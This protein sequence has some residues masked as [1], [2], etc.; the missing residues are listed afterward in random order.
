LK[1]ST[2]NSFRFQQNSNISLRQLNRRPLGCVLKSNYKGKYKMFTKIRLLNLL[3]LV[4]LFFYQLIAQSFQD[5]VDHYS[6]P[7][8]FSKPAVKVIFIKF[9][10]Q[11]IEGTKSIC[12]YLEL[13]NKDSFE[14]YR[15]S[16]HLC[17]SLLSLLQKESDRN[18]DIENLKYCKRQVAIMQTLIESPQKTSEEKHHAL[19]ICTGAKYGLQSSLDNLLDIIAAFGN[20]WK[21]KKTSFSMI[22][23]CRKSVGEQVDK[24]LLG[25]KFY[26]FQ[27]KLNNLLDKDV[28]FDPSTEKFTVVTNIGR[29]YQNIIPNRDDQLLIEESLNGE[30]KQALFDKTITIYQGSDTPIYLLFPS[31]I[32]SP[33]SWDHIVFESSSKRKSESLGKTSLTRLQ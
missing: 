12:E 17:D 19:L 14:H 5:I 13:D 27:V 3:L 16:V 10:E 6:S 31:S 15:M 18:I 22:A 11:D 25:K 33:D 2:W 32:P 4:F 7:A 29:Q 21:Y 20:T 1:V 9:L 24:T 8:K 26:L 23:T 28:V 30:D